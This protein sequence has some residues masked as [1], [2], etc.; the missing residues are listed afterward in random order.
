MPALTPL[1]VDEAR[2]EEL[3]RA[4][5]DLPSVTLTQ[6]QLCDLELLMCGAFTPLTGFM[7]RDS[8]D[9][10]LED[11]RLPDGSVWPIPVTLDITEKLA[12]SFAVGDRLALRD[13]EGFMLAV[14]TVNDMWTPDRDREAECIYATS[15]GSHPGVAYL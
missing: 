2:A 10:V 15:D 14:L 13:G 1:L 9:G 12:E 4:S 7:G 8:Y 3:K 6:R 11:S 5:L